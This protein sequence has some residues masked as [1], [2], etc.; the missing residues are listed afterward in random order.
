MLSRAAWDHEGLMFGCG[1]S[2]VYTWESSGAIL[3]L[4][5]TFLV[6]TMEN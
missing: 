3:P 5:S 1:S 6:A 2:R 4:F